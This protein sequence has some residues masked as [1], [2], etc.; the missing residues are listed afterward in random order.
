MSGAWSTQDP[1]SAALSLNGS[2]LLWADSHRHEPGLHVGGFQNLRRLLALKIENIEVVNLRFLYPSTKGLQSP[3]GAST[4][5]VSSL[6]RVWTDAGI[7][8]L[9]SVYSHPDLVRIIVEDHLREMLIGEDPLDIERLWDV[10]YGLTRWYGRKGAAI[11]AIGGID[12]A[13][14]DIR[15]KSAGKPIYQLLGGTRKSVPAYA[16]GLTWRDDPHSLAEESRRYL[17]KGFRSMKMRIG[18]NHEYDSTAMRVVRDAIGSH[19]LLMADANARYSLE[20]AQQMAPNLQALGVFWLEEPFLPEDVQNYLKF[21]PSAPISLAAGENEFGLQ[22]F[23][24]LIEQHLVDIVQPDCSRAGG[25]T[26]C[27]RIGQLACDHGLRV[28]THTWSDAVALLA[29]MHLIA[30]LN[31]GLTVEIDQT[32]NG[33]IDQLLSEPLQLIEGEVLLPSKPG[34]GIELDDEAVERYTVPKGVAVSNGNYSDL[35]FGQ[36][37]YQPADPYEVATESKFVGEP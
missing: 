28:A 6:V 25:I 35:V 3:S 34:L 32:G 18:Q 37:F 21:H 15:G 4:G 11:S 22:G 36:N 17:A 33:L 20:Q 23:R 26:E 24:E 5:R 8:G 10:C 19:N 13:L 29:N 30:S 2:D 9:G 27:R 1:T 12:I 31:N 7:V 16:S 14:W